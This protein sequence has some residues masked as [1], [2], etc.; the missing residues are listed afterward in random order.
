[1]RQRKE[2]E[3]STEINDAKKIKI[4]LIISIPA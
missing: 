4:S 1:M 2:K 3:T